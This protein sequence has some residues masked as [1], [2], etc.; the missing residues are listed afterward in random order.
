MRRLLAAILLTT[1]VLGR[2]VQGA[3]QDGP[4]QPDEAGL[5]LAAAGLTLFYLPAKGVIAGCGLLLGGVVGLVTGGDTRSAYA[6]WVPAAGGSYTITAGNLDGS[7]PFE[8]WGSD[9]ADVPSTFATTGAIYDA[10]YS[11][12]GYDQ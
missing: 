2:P 3:A 1:L 11:P 8:F 6:I 7:E 4:Y 12:M 10:Q 5:A 9:Y